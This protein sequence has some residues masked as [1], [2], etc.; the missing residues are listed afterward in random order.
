[1]APTISLAR[2]GKDIEGQRS[3]QAIASQKRS[4]ITADAIAPWVLSLL[5]WALRGRRRL[6]PNDNSSRSLINQTPDRN[7]PASWLT[8]VV[9]GRYL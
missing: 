3:R 6:L 8:G 1:M 7:S 4:A 9:H 2:Q 5:T